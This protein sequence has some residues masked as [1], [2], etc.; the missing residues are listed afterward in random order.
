[1]TAPPVD[2]D[3]RREQHAGGVRTTESSDASSRPEH[4]NGRTILVAE[5]DSQC[6][7]ALRHHLKRAG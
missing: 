4:L 3:V 6:R 2:V 1:M 7:V 5:G